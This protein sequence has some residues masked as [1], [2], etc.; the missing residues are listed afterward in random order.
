MSS[1]GCN[2][3]ASCACTEMGQQ[4]LWITKLVG[5]LLWK[6]FWKRQIGHFRLTWKEC[7]ES[8]GKRSPSAILCASIAAGHPFVCGRRYNRSLK[9]NSLGDPVSVSFWLSCIFKN[10]YL[11]IKMLKILLQDVENMTGILVG[12]S[13]HKPHISTVIGNFS[14]AI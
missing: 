3:V 7:K 12:L 2:N 10:W 8:E 1:E 13:L 14:L 4:S 6:L 5:K 9:K 11:L